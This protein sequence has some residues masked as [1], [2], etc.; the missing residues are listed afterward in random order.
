M[1]DHILH[2]YILHLLYLCPYRLHFH[3]IPHF[4]RSH[5][6]PNLPHQFPHCYQDQNH[7]WFLLLVDNQQNQRSQ[8]TW[9][10]SHYLLHL[11]KSFEN[12]QYPLHRY[13]AD[14]HPTL[15]YLQ[16]QETFPIRLHRKIGPL[17]LT[18]LVMLIHLHFEH[19]FHYFPSFP[20]DFSI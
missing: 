8:N 17:N 2:H 5:S 20:F 1:L 19:N 9:L 11:M 16:F 12:N 3:H 15:F 6:H 10:F 18:H 14:I 7:L 13:L 4:P